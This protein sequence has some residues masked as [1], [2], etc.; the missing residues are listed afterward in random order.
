MAGK[1]GAVTAA[2][3]GREA[4]VVVTALLAG[5]AVWGLVWYPYRALE[6]AGFSSTASTALTYLISL[7]VGVAGFGWRLLELR[8]HWRDAVLIGLA[9]GWTNLAYVLAMVDGE[10]MRVLLLFYL[11]PLWTVIFARVLLNEALTPASAVLVALSFAGA[12]IML[13]PQHGLPLPANGAEWLALSAGVSFAALN[14]LS[15]GAAAMSMQSRALVTWAGV[16][17]VCAV[18]LMAGGGEWRV[19]LAGWP[20]SVAWLLVGL[21]GLVMYAVTVIIQ[22]GLARV[23]ANTAIVIFLFELVAGAVS[24]ALL[25]DEVLRVQDWLGGALIVGASLVA[26]ARR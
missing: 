22:F 10:V 26:A 6:F 20:D 9:A 7:I 21:L 24:A 8:R 2:T 3:G 14:V 12:L 16:L 11:A 19:P 13:W 25:S 4:A 15:R 5:A 23:P 18:W 17:L 1:Y